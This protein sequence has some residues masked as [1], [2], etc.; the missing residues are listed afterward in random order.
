VDGQL[1][2]MARKKRVEVL[3]TKEYV[4][5]PSLKAVID[6]IKIRER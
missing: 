1:N 4:F 6:P 3:P 5:K 2:L